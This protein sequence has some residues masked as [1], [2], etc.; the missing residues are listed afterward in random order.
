MSRHAIRP[1]I[2]SS[3]QDVSSSLSKPCGFAWRPDL[4]PCCQQGLHSLGAHAHF[5]LVRTMHA[6]EKGSDLILTST[7]C[8]DICVDSDTCSCTKNIRRLHVLHC[9][10]WFCLNR[11]D[12]PYDERA[13]YT[14]SATI[15]DG[16]VR[17]VLMFWL[18]KEGQIRAI[19]PF[20]FVYLFSFIVY[21]HLFIQLL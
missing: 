12:H 16:E 3:T 21:F 8:M 20:S 7:L 17:M 4:W 2:R 1:I 9:F 18:T 6:C 19:F 5:N 11:N 14:G 13:I 10:I 15:V